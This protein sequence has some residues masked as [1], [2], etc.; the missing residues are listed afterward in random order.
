MPKL[1]IERQ[2]SRA[3]YTKP[4]D[5]R[6]L[7]DKRVN[8]TG[9]L[10]GIYLQ[11][12]PLTWQVSKESIAQALG[13]GLDAMDTALRSLR[14]AGY[15][16]I[17]KQRAN[18]GKF[19][20]VWTIREEAVPSIEEPS[21]EIPPMAKPAKSKPRYGFKPQPDNVVNFLAPSPEIPPMEESAQSEANTSV[22][23]ESPEG[24]FPPLANPPIYKLSNSNEEIN[25]TAPDKPSRGKK[26][27]SKEQAT[28]P[29]VSPDAR[30]LVSHLSDCLKAHGA[31][32]GQ[33][34]GK[35][36][37]QGCNVAGELLKVE[38]LDD[39]KSAVT[40][41][42]NDQFIGLSIVDMYAVKRQLPRWQRVRAGNAA[43]EPAQLTRAER[44]KQAKH[45]KHCFDGSTLETENLRLD[46]HKQLWDGPNRID[47]LDYE[48]ITE[49]VVA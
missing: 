47:P 8:A 30:A 26:N 34:D 41:L 3:R 37:F 42:V 45:I 13:F 10:M 16:T 14:K 36:F 46:Q 49:G 28:S 20:W 15:L 23:G 33:F 39:L 17:E 32:A 31:K 18:D 2:K 38:S 21:P 25:N 19:D 4:I 11:S 6:F 24:D 7:E 9:R 27:S 5:M 44:L 40:Y 1:I 12:L 29:T 43:S 48:P 22:L 35:W